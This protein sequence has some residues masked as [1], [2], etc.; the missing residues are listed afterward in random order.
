[1][2]PTSPASSK[3]ANQGFKNIFRHFNLIT[4]K[5]KYLA[6]IERHATPPLNISEES[7][8]IIRRTGTLAYYPGPRYTVMHPG[9]WLL[10]MARLLSLR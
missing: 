6:K 3:H 9:T 5:S 10:P 7:R 1:M 2:P 8:L 4:L